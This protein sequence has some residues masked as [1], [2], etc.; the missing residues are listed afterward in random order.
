MGI[1]KNVFTKEFMRLDLLVNM[2]V[3]KSLGSNMT[4]IWL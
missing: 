2:Q 4:Q 3:V 1:E